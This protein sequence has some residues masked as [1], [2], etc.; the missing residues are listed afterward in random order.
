[1]QTD[2]N[3]QAGRAGKIKLRR[4]AAFL[5]LLSEQALLDGTERRRESSPPPLLPRLQHQR[6]RVRQEAPTSPP[7]LRQQR[8][9]TLADNDSRWRE[10]EAAGSSNKA[11]CVLLA[12]THW[13]SF[14]RVAQQR[15]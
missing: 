6:T 3:K 5:L 4:A 11:V 2:G 8:V 13:R 9:W 10:Q 15:W 14:S 1:M 7:R 12:F